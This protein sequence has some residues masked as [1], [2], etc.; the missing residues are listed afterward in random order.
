MK[1]KKS[2]SEITYSI[3]LTEEL[4]IK[5]KNLCH[6]VYLRVGYIDEP[7]PD[8][9]IPNDL[10]HASTY[11]VAVDNDEVVG[12]LRL[13]AGPPFTTLKIW[14]DNLY[15]DCN[16]LINDILEG[17]AFEIGAL[18]VNKEYSSLKISQGLYM[19]AYNY[20]AMSGLEYGIISMDARALRTLEM[21]GWKAI[22]IGEPK[23][24]FGSLTVP[25]IMPIIIQPNV[26][27]MYLKTANNLAA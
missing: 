7:Y 2:N 4:C 17:R 24:Y 1:N 23:M 13:T 12:T 6:D 5:A 22:R 16:K 20:C 3:A 10:E 18:A 9:I 26:S 8:R 25:A 14:K 27:Q 15:A 11:I 21:N 19:S